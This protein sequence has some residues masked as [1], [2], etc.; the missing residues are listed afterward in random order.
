VREIRS[1]YVPRRVS[2]R[3]LAARYGVSQH[4]IWT[5][6]NGAWSHVGELR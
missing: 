1:S 3:T 4:C 5:V 2:Q 6:L